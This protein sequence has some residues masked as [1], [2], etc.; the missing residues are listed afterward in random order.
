MGIPSTMALSHQCLAIANLRRRPFSRDRLASRC[1]AR[2]AGSGS[3]NDDVSLNIVVDAHP[4]QAAMLKEALGRMMDK[5]A[6]V[7]PRRVLNPCFTGGEIFF[8]KTERPLPIALP[9][10]RASSPRLSPAHCQR[11]MPSIREVLSP[12]VSLI[13]AG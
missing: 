1:A 13:G 2:C 6:V 4:T 8:G 3:I 5:C 12:T 7:V 9:G 10:K 11:F